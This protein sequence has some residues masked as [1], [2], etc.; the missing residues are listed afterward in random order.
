MSELSLEEWRGRIKKEVPFVDKKPFS[1]NI[2]SIAL[3][4]IHHDYGIMEANRAIVDFK[5][6]RLGWRQITIEGSDAKK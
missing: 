3:G 1:H 6:E 4:A 5:L 2:I